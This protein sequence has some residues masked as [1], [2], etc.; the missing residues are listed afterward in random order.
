M[1]AR[2]R[3]AR[4]RAVATTAP[5]ILRAEDNEARNHHDRQQRHG[6]RAGRDGQSHAHRHQ[7]T[8]DSQVAHKLVPLNQV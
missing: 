4:P 2:P 6:D 3:A 7:C 1:I 8:E 5:A